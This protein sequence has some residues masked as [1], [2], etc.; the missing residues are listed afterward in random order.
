VSKYG[1]YNPCVEKK[2][3]NNREREFRQASL[4]VNG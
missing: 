2:K 4:V 3:E 1:L